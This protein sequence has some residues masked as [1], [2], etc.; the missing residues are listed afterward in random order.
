MNDI[1]IFGTGGFGREV[2]ELL[3]D[4]NIDQSTWNVLGWLDNNKE[5]HGTEI[6][7]LPVL[8]DASWMSRHPAVHTIIAVGGPAPKSRIVQS[9]GAVRFATLIH[10]D[11]K[12][13]SRVGVDAGT[14]ICEGTLIT[15]NIAIGR[16]VIVNLG[17]TVSHDSQLIDFVTIA[18]GVNISGNVKIGK[19]ADIGTGAKIIQGVDIGPWSVVGAGSVVN[20]NV[21]A[22]T[23]SVGVP[24]KVIKERP[25]GWHC[26]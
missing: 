8:G 6:H 12:I 19:G 17:C 10:P 24:A 21:P 26:Q 11:V 1:V 14:I 15:T 13:R 3:E 23:T 16:H 22:N 25:E 20:R 18:P 7:A 9:M 2:A 5:K 4:I